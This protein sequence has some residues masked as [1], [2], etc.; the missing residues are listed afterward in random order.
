MAYDFTVFKKN[1]KG[2]VE[3]LKKELSTIRTSRATA[4]L[5]DAVVVDAYGAKM[6][7]AQV[8]SMSTEDARTLRVAPWDA[9][10]VK[11]I[12]K[13]ISLAN[14][15]V[16]VTADD[17]GIRVHFPELTGER[18]AMLGKL[19]KERLEQARITLRVERD[20]VW[21]D[22]QEKERAGEIPTDDKFHAKEGL[23]KIMDETHA[24]FED[25]NERKQKEILS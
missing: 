13:A 3:W 7:I 8:A 1:T 4:S 12:E 6:P 20:K 2:V 24:V 22:V 17:Q 23:Q 19:A 11:A 10:L 16:S 25:M 15:G 5:L 21:T 9:S 14:L 18:R